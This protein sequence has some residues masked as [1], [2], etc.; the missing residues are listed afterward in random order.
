MGVG[1]EFF[2]PGGGQW[3]SVGVSVCMWGGG[4]GIGGDGSTV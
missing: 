4:G 2:V 3:G 1:G